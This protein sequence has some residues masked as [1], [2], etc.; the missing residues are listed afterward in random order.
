M[1][2]FRRLVPN[3]LLVRRSRA[4]EFERRAARYAV[5]DQI[6][7]TH[8]RFFAAAAIVNSAL[9]EAL[10]ESPGAYFLP[11]GTTNF[12]AT[13][14]AYLEPYNVLFAR[15]VPCMAL[16]GPALDQW[17]VAHEQVLVERHLSRYPPR[18]GRAIIRD[19][20][21][22]LWAVAVLDLRRAA[23][24]GLAR[25]VEATR[26]LRTRQGC[27]SFGQLEDRQR[28]GCLLASLAR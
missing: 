17:L 3:A 13:L 25:L 24:D 10:A 1:T 6:L 20:D 22:L 18:I 11:L 23:S 9:A 16:R 21:R 12:L 7:R 26:I 8:T 27:L 19:V 15:R 2:G 14:S 28:L 5:C 4:V